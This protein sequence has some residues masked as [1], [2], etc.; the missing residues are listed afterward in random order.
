MASARLRAEPLSNP[1]TG[2][3]DEILRASHPSIGERIDFANTYHPWWDR[4]TPPP[5]ADADRAEGAARSER[6]DSVE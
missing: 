3:S 2:L 4:P 5:G 6:T 1:R